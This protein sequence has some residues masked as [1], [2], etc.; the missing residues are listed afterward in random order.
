MHVKQHLGEILSAFEYIGREAYDL[1]VKNGHGKALN[2]EDAAG[3]EC[4]VLL[5]TS[6]GD[7][8][9]DEEVSNPGCV[10]RRLIK[11]S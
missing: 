7:N 11:S 5:E 9:H 3:A 4:F 1:A 8:K 10:V 6:G 2:D